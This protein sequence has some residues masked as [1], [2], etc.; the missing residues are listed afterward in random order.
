MTDGCDRTID[1]LRVS[2]TDRCNL[3]CMYCM[4]PEGVRSIRHEQILS[5]EEIIR[6]CR[7]LAG[8]GI[9]RIKVTGGEPLVRKDAI[10]LIRELKAIDGIE[11]VTMTSNGILLYDRLNELAD[12]GLDALNLSLD[13]LDADVFTRITRCGDGLDKTLAALDAAVSLGFPIKINCVPIR[14]VNE[15]E[16]VKIAALAKDRDIA[17]RFIELMPLGCGGAYEP[18]PYEEVFAALEQAYGVLTPFCGRLGN[19]PALYY[20]VRGFRGKLGFISA[21]SRVFCQNCNRLRMT[22]AGIMKLCLADDMGLNVKTLLRGGATDTEIIQALQEFIIQ[23]PLRHGF[24]KTS[25]ERQ[26]MYRIGG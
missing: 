2:V 16:I 6:L 11:Q 19:G 9:R 8:L 14:N 23:K 26:N 12:A 24:G 5:F 1:Y 22:S 15:P 10:K 4:P 25:C 7:V 3:R 13:T 21:L 20:T 17:V 18:I